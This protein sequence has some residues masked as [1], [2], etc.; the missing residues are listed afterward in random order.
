MSGKPLSPRQQ[1]AVKALLEERTLAAA[2]DAVQVSERQIY[3]WLDQPAFKAE[4]SRHTSHVMEEV[5]RSLTVLAKDAVQALAEVLERPDQKGA[6]VKR[7]T[8]VSILEH[9][10]KFREFTELEERLTFLEQQLQG[11]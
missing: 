11:R 10:Q 4:L 3:R 9:C 1:S 7:L 8:A 6:A 5:T 2:A